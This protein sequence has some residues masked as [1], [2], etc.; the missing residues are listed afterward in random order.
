MDHEDETDISFDEDAELYAYLRRL[1]DYLFE[2]GPFPD[3]A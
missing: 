2:D 1:Y 3:W